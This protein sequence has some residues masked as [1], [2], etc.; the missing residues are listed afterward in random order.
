MLHSFNVLY[1][2]FYNAIASDEF[3]STA[4]TM[5]DLQEQVIQ[6]NE[7][8]RYLGQTN[9]AVFIKDIDADNF[10][11]QDIT[12]A[13]VSSFAYQVFRNTEWHY[14]NYGESIPKSDATYAQAG[15]RIYAKIEKDDNL[16][17]R[18]IFKTRELDYYI[19][20]QAPLT[21]FEYFIN[22]VNG[23]TIAEEEEELVSIDEAARTI[24]TLNGDIKLIN[25]SEVAS[26]SPGDII[27]A[28]TI[29]DKILGVSA[30]D[31]TTVVTV[32]QSF[33]HIASSIKA[34][35]NLQIIIE[36]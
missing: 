36:D 29:L 9:M 33:K 32:S 13:N 31:G 2:H 23:C 26:L 6:L 12:G 10:E 3:V 15:R 14:V 5:L 8:I 20:S 34:D 4:K 28:Y 35:I 19:L 24:T 21:K 22:A 11:L 17:G 16:I 18:T 7:D 1:P 25:M 27:P 30:D